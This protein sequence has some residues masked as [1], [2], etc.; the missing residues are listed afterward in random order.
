MLVVV[1]LQLS[2]MDYSLR[3][4]TNNI[5]L[6]IESDTPV[7]LCLL[8]KACVDFHLGHKLF[9]ILNYKMYQTVQ[10]PQQQIQKDWLN[11]WG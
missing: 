8:L 1:I 11:S 6:Q 10:I 2:E 9:Q 5:V 7:N 4:T 3:Q